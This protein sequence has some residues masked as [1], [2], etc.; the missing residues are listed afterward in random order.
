MY[1]GYQACMH[2]G[3]ATWRQLRLHGCQKIADTRTATWSMQTRILNTTWP[4]RAPPH[5][6]T[7]VNQGWR[8]S[9]ERAGVCSSLDGDTGL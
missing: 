7:R 2:G 1:E 4:E 9:G 6:L 3:A 5:G 8:G